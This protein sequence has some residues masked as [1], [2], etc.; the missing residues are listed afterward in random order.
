MDRALLKS[1]SRS[2]YLSMAWLPP[3][4][5]HSVALGYMLARAIWR[6]TSARACT[7]ALEVSATQ[8]VARGRM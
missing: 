5:R 8:S 3:A 1:V 7:A 4:M 6:R 2:F